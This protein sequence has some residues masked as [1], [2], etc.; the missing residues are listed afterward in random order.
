MSDRR[1]ESVFTGKVASPGLVHGRIRLQ[2]RPIFDPRSAGTPAEE[3]ALLE[4]AIG[5]A[6]SRLAELSTVGDE[7]ARAILEFQIAL[8]E[9]SELLQPIRRFIAEGTSAPVAWN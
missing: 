8:L 7:A 6:A 5:A 2:A 3:A 9:D 4:S 1:P